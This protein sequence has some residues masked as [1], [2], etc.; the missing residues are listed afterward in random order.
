MKQLYLLY[1]LSAISVQGYTQ[2]V[3]GTILNSST[4]E[5]VPYVNIGIP[6]TDIGTVSN[7]KE[8]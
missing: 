5:P 7:E 2:S 4:N 8:F 1:F 6:G 3:S